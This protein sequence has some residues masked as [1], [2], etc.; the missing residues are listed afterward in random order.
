[1]ASTRPSCIAGTRRRSA[2][3][4]AAPPARRAAS[5]GQGPSPTTTRTSSR[6]STST[7][8]GMM[9]PVPGIG[10]VITA[11]VT[12]F[13]ERLEVDEEAFVE[14]MAHLARH[15]SDG[16]VVCGTTG[17][18]P[19]LS[20]DEHLRLVELAAP[21]RPEGTTV[22]AR[23]R[24]YAHHPPG[25]PTAPPPRNPPPRAPGP[26]APPRRAPPRPS[27]SLRTTTGP[28]GAGCAATTRRS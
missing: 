19:T 11:I 28:I 1:M 3:R 9:A 5:T 23:T 12:P 6:A 16:F 22:I 4:C 7:T 24:S 26:G 14:L 25:P 10:T 20:D 15:G 8:C 21:E 2:V 27:G 18:A 17:E 13:D